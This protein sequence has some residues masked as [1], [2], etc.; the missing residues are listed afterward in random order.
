ME[1]KVAPEISKALSAGR[2]I[3]AMEST[4]FSPLGLPLPQRRDALKRCKQVLKMTHSKN[5]KKDNNKNGAKNEL[6]VLPAI[7]AILDGQIYLGLTEEQEEKI[8]AQDKAVKKVSLRD[9][10]VAVAQKW[11]VGVTTVSATIAIAAE[12]GIRVMATGGI[13]GVHREAK[14]DLS[15][16]ISADL[17]ALGKYPVGVVCSG[18]KGFLD[19]PS[20]IEMLETLGVPVIGYGTDT[21]PAFWS[22]SS[23]LPVPF[24]VDEP[25]HIA[26][27]LKELLDD[28]GAVVAVPVPDEAGLNDMEAVI[29]KAL[30]EAE[31]NGVSGAATTPFILKSITKQTGG[32]SLKANLA[33]LENNARVAGDIARAIS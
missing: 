11:E 20:T 23:G 1:I 4:V 29:S 12:V 30:S 25:K 2:P 10:P 28:I 32:E 24:Q 21:F 7:T 9:I 8:L 22:A 27:I 19:L 31:K 33:L 18:A 5:T 3:V 14:Q 6:E 15:A 16:D 26:N 13:G 17:T